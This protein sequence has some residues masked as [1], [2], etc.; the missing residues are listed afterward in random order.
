[1]STKPLKDPDSASSLSVD[2]AEKLRNF[3]RTP[4]PYVYDGGEVKQDR[5]SSIIEPTRDPQWQSTQPSTDNS[6]SGTEADDERRTFVKALP[7]S[8]LRPRKGLKTGEKDEDS[9][10]EPSQ[11]DEEERRVQS[12][13]L[14]RQ[15]STRS[16]A[17]KIEDVEEERAEQ[18]RV[19][20]RRIAEFVRRTSEVA[21]MGLIL[22]CVLC[23]RGVLRTAWEWRRELI[24]HILIVIGLVLAYPLKL[25]IVD[26]QVRH[27]Q[28]WQR[29]RVPA[30]FD[31]ATVLYP[32]LL[33]VLVALSVAPTNPAVILPN[34]ILGL[35]SLPQR[36]FPRSS[37][38]GRV[39]TV[40]WVVSIIPLVI[41]QNTTWPFK[42]APAMPYM[43]KCGPPEGLSPETLVSLYALHHALLQP[44][45]YLTTTSLL[46]SEL[47]LLSVALINLLLLA[48]SP[49]AVILK[50]CLW[51]GGIPLLV[52]CAHVVHWNVTLARV[53]K[54]K[55]RRP[56]HPCAERKSF[57]DAV[58]DL[59]NLQRAS[60]AFHEAPG[61]V[62]S[63]ADEDEPATSSKGGLNSL[64]KLD[65]T[66]RTVAS[67]I[68]GGAV[69]D[70][71]TRSAIEPSHRRSRTTVDRHLAATPMARRQT[72]PGRPPNRSPRRSPSVR[73]KGR[74]SHLLWCLQLTPAQAQQR[75]WIYAGFT[76]II[77]VAIILGPVR[78]YVSNRAL[79]G[80]E[81]IGWA[82]SY[83]FGQLP[84]IRSITE[85]INLDTWIPLS[86]AAWTWSP[87]LSIP[88]HMD[89]IASDIGQANVRLLLIAY[90]IGVLLVGLL[91]VF[92]LTAY[93]EVDT[94]RKIFHGVM[95]AMLLPATF[96]DPCF[97]ALA[98]TLVLAVFLLLEV[99]R[100][101][102]V[103]P[104]G[105]AISRFVAPYVDGRDLRGPVVVSH[106]FLL[107]GCA[108]PLWFSLASM[109]REGEPP[110]VDWQMRNNQRETA[111]IAG[112]VCVGMGDAAASLIGRRYGRRKW[113]WVGGK[114][115]EGSAA[116]A[117]AVT[118]GL[119]AARTW[120]VFGGWN[121]HPTAWKA[122]GSAGGLMGF[123]MEWG[124][125][126]MKATICACGASFMEAVLTGANDN[127]VVPVALWLLVK[128]VRL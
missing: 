35:A 122:L 11:L 3:S 7:A 76:Y 113:I 60:G 63:D 73:K 1:M 38:L 29:F 34:I 43:L 24:S 109:D 78:D 121:D 98:L 14:Q 39:N 88:L 128:G 32:P 97:C 115:L 53:P 45:Q 54:W 25:S 10:L 9:L 84:L 18:E 120:Q 107:I 5:V 66:I 118:F 50:A 111:M 23:G 90:W 95:V 72:L 87:S 15:A 104:L 91:A 79:G 19:E 46:V 58:S 16:H 96:V 117:V 75:K 110:W 92:S 119:M 12:W 100:A 22:V 102:Q 89:I 70:N 124:V 33:P 83:M 6:E 94:R 106:I 20:K 105:N 44:L 26:T 2:E 114:S 65:T 101:G 31:P 55:L 69:S 74:S 47:H 49:Q 61:S 41:S 93:V 103:P 42:D 126:L 17:D 82:L 81:P 30:S 116:F 51:V 127:V 125:A 48:T 57:A 13:F 56:V 112:V 71:E 59:I 52:L 108:V 8:T 85:F 62:T 4:R 123:G 36:I 37:R 67:A 64:L 27:N 86:N 28:L 80:R 21:L 40:H 99:I 77:I 68:K